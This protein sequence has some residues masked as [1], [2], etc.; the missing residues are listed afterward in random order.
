[1]LGLFQAVYA[2]QSKYLVHFSRSE[3][4]LDWTW[5]MLLAR[6]TR[7]AEKFETPTACVSSNLA[8][9]PSPSTKA[10]LKGPLVRK[11]GQCCM[12]SPSF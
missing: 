3:Q 10:S 8:Q 2:C 4:L 9:S 6:R 7:S 12:Y 11:P 5:R 1:M